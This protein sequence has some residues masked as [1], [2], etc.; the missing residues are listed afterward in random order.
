[1]LIDTCEKRGSSKAV[2]EGEHEVNKKRCAV[3]ASGES[4]SCNIK[5]AAHE[6]VIVVQHSSQVPRRQTAPVRFA[7]PCALI[8]LRGTSSSATFTLRRGWR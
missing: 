4:G 6:Q 8:W 3:G 7:P 1:M 5:P 2:G